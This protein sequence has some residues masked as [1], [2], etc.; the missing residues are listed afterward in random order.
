METLRVIQM[1]KTKDKLGVD[2]SKRKFCGC[3]MVLRFDLY[4]N[5]RI[6]DVYNSNLLYCNKILIFKITH[7]SWTDN[8]VTCKMILTSTNVIFIVKIQGNVVDVK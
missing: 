7:A 6:V 1:K 8:M 4:Q 2:R 3:L 5:D